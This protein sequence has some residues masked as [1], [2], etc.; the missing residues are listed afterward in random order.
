[1]WR[2]TLSYGNNAVCNYYNIWLTLSQYCQIWR[3]ISIFGNP[4]KSVSENK[5]AEF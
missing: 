4:D 5:S 2:F 1:M 3:L